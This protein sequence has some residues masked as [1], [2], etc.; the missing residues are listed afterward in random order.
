MVK[1]DDAPDFGSLPLN[2]S[3]KRIML[4]L[5]HIFIEFFL[6]YA[7]LVVFQDKDKSLIYFQS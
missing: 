4:D 2:I 6:S 1:I 5:S 3:L 7:V